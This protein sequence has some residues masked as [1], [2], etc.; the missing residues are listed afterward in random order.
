MA[1]QPIFLGE[2][3]LKRLTK[4]TKNSSFFIVKNFMQLRILNNFLNNSIKHLFLLKIVNIMQLVT[5]Y[6][7]TVE[8]VSEA[9]P[10]LASLETQY[11]K[12]RGKP[13][14]SKNHSIIQGNVY[15]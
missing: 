5:I 12:E 8:T 13:M 4:V 2:N 7:T 6:P 1:T 14:P 3:E 15:F 9:Q 10:I 11:E